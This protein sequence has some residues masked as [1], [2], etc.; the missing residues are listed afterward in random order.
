MMLTELS[1][2]I[3]V[4]SG[5]FSLRF[6]IVHQYVLQLAPP[7][8]GPTQLSV[9]CNTASDVLQATESWAGP[10]NEATQKGH[11]IIISNHLQYRIFHSPCTTSYRTYH[12]V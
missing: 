1:C 2:Y 12:D 9:A 7:S 4:Q 11:N 8:F 6:N 3:S 5:P 10:G